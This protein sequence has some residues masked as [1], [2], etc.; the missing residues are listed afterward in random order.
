MP[1]GP[2]NT[3]CDVP[4][5]KVGQA[6]DS[7]AQTGVTVILPDMAAV[8][9]VDVRGGGP[10]TRET[11]ALSLSGLVDQ[12]NGIVLSG[13]SVY[14]LGAADRVAAH[15]GAARRGF[16]LIPE[17]TVPVSPI[18]PAA[19]L[20]DLNNGGN[21][22]WGTTPPYADLAVQAYE[23]ASTDVGLGRVGAG[24]GATA[25]AHPGG[26]GSAS[27]V[28]PDGAIMGGLVAV[29]SFGS[30]YVPGTNQF[31]AAPWEQGAEFGGRGIAPFQGCADFPPDTK[32]GIGPGGNTTVAVVATD[33]SL[34]KAEANRVAV[35][36]QT[37]MARAIRPVH[38]PTDG[39]TVF[40][41]STAARAMAEPKALTTTMLGNVAADVL[42]RSIAR[43]AHAAETEV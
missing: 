36:A 40:V 25:G 27:W 31:W 18:V 6:E 5:L 10:G 24:C 28:M 34:T 1:I 37:G 30:P 43:G 38:G 4:G 15:L 11:D 21:K 20:Y 19:I 41:L 14:G 39:D 9:A 8:A 2:Q 7:H 29:N 16:S 33:I 13:G 22:D 23:T 12:V 35:M 3:I 26:M 32:I 42:A 17:E